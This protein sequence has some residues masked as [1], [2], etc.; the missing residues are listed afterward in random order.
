MQRSRHPYRGHLRW[1]NG[2]I[3]ADVEV[4]IGGVFAVDRR[5]DEDDAL[6]SDGVVGVITLGADVGIAVF[7]LI[8]RA[9]VD[10]EAPDDKDVARVGGLQILVLHKGPSLLLSRYD[11]GGARLLDEATGVV[12]EVGQDAHGVG[13]GISRV[14]AVEG[15]RLRV[16][17]AETLLGALV[18]AVAGLTTEV[19]AADV[20]VGLLDFAF[21]TA[22]LRRLAMGLRD[23]QRKGVRILLMRSSFCART[24]TSLW[25]DLPTRELPWAERLECELSE[26]AMVAMT[27][28][29]KTRGK[30]LEMV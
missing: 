8:G 24:L 29:A 26:S 12:G 11:G 22:A 9:N 7:G 15:D 14:R 18:L 20:A 13:D 6:T 16:R 17:V 27:G 25:R 28:G 23:G 4:R 30:I 1:Q 5:A 3:V 2:Q 10:V 21:S 19:L